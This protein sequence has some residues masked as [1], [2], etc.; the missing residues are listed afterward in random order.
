MENRFENFTVTVLKLGKLIQKIKLFEMEDFCLKAVHVMCI[1]YSGKRG[2]VTATELV[3]LT[4]EDKA[5]ISRALALLSEKGYVRYDTRK[6]N[7]AV[8]LTE[9][10][11]KVYDCISERAAAAVDAGGGSLTDGEREAFY[12]MLGRI[13]RDLERYYNGLNEIR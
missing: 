7:S 6:Y 11:K 9:E 12:D 13:E 10:G 4:W 1:Y 5:A 2:S 8:T 3:S